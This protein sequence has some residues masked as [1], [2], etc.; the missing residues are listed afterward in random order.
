MFVEYCVE[1]GKLNI[2]DYLGL[3]YYLILQDR[4]SEAI[5]IF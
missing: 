4:I 5:E 2:E 1:K 3:V